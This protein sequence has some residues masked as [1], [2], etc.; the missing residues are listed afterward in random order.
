MKRLLIIPIIA[1]LVGCVDG[2][3]AYHSFMDGALTVYQ[4]HAE[5]AVEESIKFLS[6]MDHAWISIYCSDCYE[7]GITIAQQYYKEQ[8]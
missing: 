7:D 5:Y 8:V 6:Y 4:E 1:A 3:E 2:H